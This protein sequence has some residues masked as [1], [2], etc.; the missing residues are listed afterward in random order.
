MPLPTGLRRD[1]GGIFQLRIGVPDDIRPFWPRL[2]NGKM[3]VDAYRRSLKTR[4][5]TE[6]VT[7]A[8]ALIAD[9]QQQ[10]ALLRDQHRP[11]FTQLTP[12]LIAHLEERIKHELLHGDDVRR[13]LGRVLDTI[14]MDLVSD[15]SPD[16]T[17]AERL[18]LWA[19][20]TREMQANGHY[21]LT[22]FMMNGLLH[23]MGLPPAIWTQHPS[24]LARLG[25]ILAQT[26]TAI[27][28]RSTGELIDTPPAPQPYVAEVTA[29]ALAEAVKAQVFT[30]QDAVPH[31]KRLTSALPNAI[32]RMERALELWEDAVGTMPLDQ[33][34]R[35]TG[36]EFVLYLLDEEREFKRK[37]AA[38]HASNINA[39]MNVA[40]RQGLI[41]S[42][43][44]DL[45]FT[46]NDSAEREPWTAQQLLKLHGQPVQGAQPLDV[47][48]ADADLLISM[49][50]WSGAR[51]SE[52][53][54]LRV[55]DVQQRDGILAAYIR[56]ETTKNDQSVRWL[57]I[58]SALRQKVQ[59]H[60]DRRRDEG[61]IALFPS[62]HRRA[63]TSAG[64]MAGRWFRLHREALALPS[65]HLNGSHKWRH[66][67]RTKLAAEGLGEAL[68]DAVTGHQAAGGS[69]GRKSY[70]HADQFPLAKVLEAVERLAWPW[71]ARS[72]S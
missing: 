30:L 52:I 53:A 22:I 54:G 67:V 45:K 31:W 14:P 15:M 8:H 36:G 44:L 29:P 47:D 2:P 13:V 3:A 68:L 49:L 25:R 48:S 66:T 46:I 7:K 21:G 43:P 32:Q 24:P 11:R 50:L 33:I 9:Y 20:V 69:A 63:G 27:A 41:Q 58:A 1:S 42:N 5:R 17:N 62:F 18:Q 16:L 23:H 51:V 39:L 71:P 34:T 12:K 4:D 57:P 28:E 65:G 35:K 59:A 40:A 37:T 56:R 26:F 10:F 38:N 64:D 6:A 60:A 55:Q 61:S 72:T 70:T 19:R